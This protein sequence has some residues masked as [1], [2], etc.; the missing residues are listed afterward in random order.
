MVLIPLLEVADLVVSEGALGIPPKGLD[1]LVK[2]VVEMI[3][4]KLVSMLRKEIFEHRKE[5]RVVTVWHQM[6]IYW[7]Y[8]FFCFD[9]TLG[10]TQRC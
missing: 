10:K 4:Y 7:I 8:F 1:Y 3:L 2:S 9:L 5:L 6:H